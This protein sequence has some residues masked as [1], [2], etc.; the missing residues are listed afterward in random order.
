MAP[1]L[2][3]PNLL[4]LLRLAVVPFIVQATLGGAHVRALVLFLAAGVTDVLDGAI[5]RRFGAS[6]QS[7][8]YL[9]P[10]ADKCLLGGVYLAL[11]GAKIVPWWFVGLVLG[12]DLYIVTAVLVLMGITS[13]RRFPPS[14]L[15][16]AS[17]FFQISAAVIWMVRN[18]APSPVLDAVAHASLWLSAAVTLASAV[19]YTWRGT[20]M[21]RSR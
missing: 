16:K 15:G 21:L 10:V 5:A 13:L 9:D 3:L 11:A 6:S 19:D 18:T 8:A 14:S 4:T 2:T 7:G 1:W 20:R 17:T 12:R